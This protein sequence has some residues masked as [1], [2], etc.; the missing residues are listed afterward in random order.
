MAAYYINSYDIIDPE[1]FSA[2]GPRVFPLLL[3]YGAEVLASDVQ[4]IAVEGMA[5]TMNAIIRF[6]SE[7]AA[8]QC[9]KDPEYE[10]IKSIR[11]KSTAN[12]TMILVKEF[13][14]F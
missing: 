1:A 14:R 5:R 8:L 13:Q 6:P 9:Y 4:A 2:Y 11:L 3:K 12:C 7:E 10:P